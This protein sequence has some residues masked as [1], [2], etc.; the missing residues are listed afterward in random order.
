M[1]LL[2]GHFGL[3]LFLFLDVFGLV[4]THLV[5]NFVLKIKCLMLVVA[6]LFVVCTL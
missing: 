3:E 6:N 2:L 4:I 5:E 1:A